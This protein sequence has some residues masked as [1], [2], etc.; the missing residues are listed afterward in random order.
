M[1]ALPSHILRFADLPT[2]RPTEAVLEPEAEARAAIAGALGLRGLRKLRFSA[3]L[4]PLGARDWQL[5]GTLGATV[6]QD[7]VVTLDPVTTR[8]DEAVERTYLAEMGWEEG[9]EVEVPEDVSA[10]P[11]PESIDLAAIL[12]EAL[13]LALPP[14]PRAPGAEV[15]AA[16]FTEPGRTPMRDEDARPFAGLAALR[17]RLDDE[18]GESG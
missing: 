4:A 3:R 11:L 12:V 7:C 15:G 16:V 10:E 2:G 5:C 1:S 17:D 9:G 13:S 18:D 6:V 8:I 14:Y